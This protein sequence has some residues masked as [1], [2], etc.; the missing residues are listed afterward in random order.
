MITAA[1]AAIVTLPCFAQ[2]LLAPQVP[3]LEMHVVVR[4]VLYVG[5]DGWLRHHH[6]PHMQL[7]QRGGLTRIVQAH[8]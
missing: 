5:A 8:D 2:C 4:H 6:L 1:V 3:H 7:V